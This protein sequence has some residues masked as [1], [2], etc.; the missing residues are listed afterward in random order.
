MPDV[1]HPS[2]H[3]VQGELLKAA[4]YWPAMIFGVISP[5]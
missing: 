5:M 2:A 4:R 1:D 3:P